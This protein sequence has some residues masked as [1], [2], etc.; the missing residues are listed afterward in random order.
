MSRR[1]LVQRSCVLAFF[2]ALSAFLFYVGKG[3][4]I[5]L[6]TRTL[7]IDGKEYRSAETV[8]VSVDGGK[9]ETM[10]RMERVMVTV[11]G[12]SHRIVIED[13]GSGTVV[14]KR[15]SLPTFAGMMLVSVP[16]ILR[17][18]PSAFWVTK[19]TAPAREAAPA[20][21]MQ[22]EG[23]PTAAATAPATAPAA[24]PAAAPATSPAASP[25]APA[26]KP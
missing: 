4:T 2:L 16:A 22:R 26:V 12:P 13:L 1:S 25:G 6:D 10:G 11:S 18:A 17:D 5:L 21:Q 19:F 15:F 24:A 20:E 7:T 23:D 14:T 9:A 8:D 3:H